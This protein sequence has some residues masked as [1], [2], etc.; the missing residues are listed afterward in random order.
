MAKTMTEI[1]DDG[2]IVSHKPTRHQR[3]STERLI[4]W[5][6]GPTTT[7]GRIARALWG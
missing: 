1:G 2:R 7:R 5:T 6:E 4:P 3:K